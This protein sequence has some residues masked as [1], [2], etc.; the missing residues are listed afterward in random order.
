MDK[1]RALATQ[2]YGGF[3]DQRT[4]VAQK[5][6]RVIR[7]IGAAYHHHQ[8]I[9]ALRGVDLHKTG[10][11]KVLFIETGAIL[12]FPSQVMARV[13]RQVQVPLAGV[14]VT[15]QGVAIQHAMREVAAQ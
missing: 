5:N 15:N 12:V 14:P 2:G 13:I 3:T 10:L 4:V 6:H 9:A 11:R 1:K 7:V 8:H